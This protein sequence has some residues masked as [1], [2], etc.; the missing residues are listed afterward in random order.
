MPILDPL[1]GIAP[2]LGRQGL[3]QVFGQAQRLSHIAQ[4]AAR[5]VADD[6]GAQGGPVPP[7]GVVDP[8]D[9]LLAALVLEID[10]DVRRLLALL[11]DEAFEQEVV[12][13]RIDGGD[14]Q[15]EADGGVGGRAS[16]LTQD[17]PATGEA[18]DGVNGQEIGRIAQCLDQSELVFQ[19]R[20]HLVRQSFRIP[21]CRPLPGQGLQRLLRGLARRRLARILVGQLVQAEAAAIGDLDRPRQGLRIAGEQPVHFPDRLQVPVGRPAPAK[22]HVVDGA[23]FPNAGD[24]VLQDAPIRVVEQDVVGDHGGHPRLGR[25]L[26]ELVQPQLVTGSPEQG[27][28]QMSLPTECI[29]HQTQTPSQHCVRALGDQ[30]RDEPFGVGGDI[31]PSEPTGALAAAPF[32]HGQEPAEARVGRP[33]PRIDQH[34]GPV[35]QH[36][37]TAHDQANARHPGRHM[38]PDDP[39]QAVAVRHRQR[40]QTA[41]GRLREELLAGTGPPQE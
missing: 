26:R 3:D 39:G 13:P 20:P 33:I 12:A 1:R 22:A 24:H 16:P 29:G 31:V 10:V 30:H 21:V 14:A 37:T 18:D 4:G 2:D 40:F 34:L 27:Q 32:A 38:G 9:H 36:Q 19:R 15:Y 7:V 17:V 11:T 25:H 41:H 23:A 5:A 8:L 35:L 28:R 6:G